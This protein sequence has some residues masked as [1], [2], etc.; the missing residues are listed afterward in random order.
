[1][2]EGRIQSD[3]QERQVRCSIFCSDCTDVA[4]AS[5]ERRDDDTRDQNVLLC[6]REEIDQ[7]VGGRRLQLRQ[8]THAGSHGGRHREKACD[9]EG[10]RDAD[11]GA[12]AIVA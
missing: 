5:V 10:T 12:N 6:S 1:M 11:V 8:A 2:L 9:I 4:T 7:R 3:G